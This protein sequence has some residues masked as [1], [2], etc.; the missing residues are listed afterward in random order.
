MLLFVLFTFLMFFLPLRTSEVQLSVIWAWSPVIDCCWQFLCLL[1]VCRVF[2]LFFLLC[3]IPSVCSNV[4]FLS[5]VPGQIEKQIMYCRLLFLLFTV[6]LFPGYGIG[7]PQN[8]P[9]TSN[10]SEFI[11]RYKSDG[12]MD[13]LHDKWYKVVPCGN[14][15]FAVTEV[16]VTAAHL[17]GR[18]HLFLPVAGVELLRDQTWDAFMKCILFQPSQS[19]Q[20]NMRR[21][22][23]TSDLDWIYFLTVLRWADA[24]PCWSLWDTAIKPHKGRLKNITQTAVGNRKP[25]SNTARNQLLTHCRHRGQGKYIF[26]LF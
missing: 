5:A 20:N 10:V 12:Y 3:S 22:L 18:G 14:R 25:V 19:Q 26:L 13:L 11:S 17:C 23:D 1:F 8:S 2:V 16:S 4:W 21:C 24:V 7:L 15:V 9:L 6:Y